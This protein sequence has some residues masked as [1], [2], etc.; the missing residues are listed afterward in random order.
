MRTGWTDRFL[1]TV[2]DAPGGCWQWA[3]YLMPNGAHASASTASGSTRTRASYE[4]FVA[5]IPDGLVIDAL[6]HTEDA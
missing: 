6:C 4:A 5:L 3:S 2:T 1:T